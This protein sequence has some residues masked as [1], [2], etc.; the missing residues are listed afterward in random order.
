M[1][2]ETLRVVAMVTCAA[3]LS[4][5][6]IA[7]TVFALATCGERRGGVRVRGVGRGVGSVFPLAG[8]AGGGA[9]R[10]ARR[11]GGVPS[12]A[13]SGWSSRRRM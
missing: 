1:T 6:T 5:Y 9:V 10:D 12:R 3:L 13:G 2:P 11:V 4:G 7:I 8:G